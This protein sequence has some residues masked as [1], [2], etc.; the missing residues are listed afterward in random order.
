MFRPGGLMRFKQIGASPKTFVLIFETGD[1]LAGGLLEFAR[2]QKLPSASF[3]AV[4]AL[5][6]VRLAWHNWET[7]K[8]DA[9]CE[10]NQ[11]DEAG[12][13]PFAR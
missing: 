5:S 13:S 3:D 12:G 8:Y 6:S 2:D 10:S 7:K 1:E 4:G 9:S 11:G